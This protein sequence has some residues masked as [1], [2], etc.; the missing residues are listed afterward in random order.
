MS[1]KLVIDSNSLI[2]LFRYYEKISNFNSIINL[3]KNEINNKNI[4]VIDKV[5]NELNSFQGK[6]EDSV[7]KKLDIEQKNCLKSES[8][9]P[10][11]MVESNKWYLTR[12]ENI[13]KYKN[14]PEIIESDKRLFF[15][16]HADLFLVVACKQLSQEYDVI[17]ITDETINEKYNNKL[18]PKIPTICK[19]EKIKYENI[20]NMLFEIYKDKISINA[21]VK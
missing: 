1:R 3:I 9:L 21:E 10:F 12:N 4:I 17:L 11:L 16:E 2:N 8:L 13:P 5:F 7:L 18:Y 14:K 20:T 19:K 6:E 15:E